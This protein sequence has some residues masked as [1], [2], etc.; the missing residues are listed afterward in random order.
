MSL[1][2]LTRC[3]RR[4]VLLVVA[5]HMWLMK[6]MHDRLDDAFDAKVLMPTVIMAPEHD[7]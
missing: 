7:I 4:D 6:L 1:A 2:S 3:I 5:L